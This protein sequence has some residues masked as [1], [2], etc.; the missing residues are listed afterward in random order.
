MK[1]RVFIVNSA[2]GY[3]VNNSK[4]RE[5]V[6]RGAPPM[7]SYSALVL[8]K[9]VFPDEERETGNETRKIKHRGG[10]ETCPAPSYSAL[11]LN[12]RRVE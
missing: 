8:N 1:K 5:Q 3:V 7:P 12:K 2:T 4:E 10:L 11:V 6:K 9:G